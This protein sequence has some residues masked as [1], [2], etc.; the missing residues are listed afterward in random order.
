[1]QNMEI[2]SLKQAKTINKLRVLN[3]I[4]FEPGVT[5]NMI[6]EK[7][8][9][10]PS[11]VTKLVNEMKR[12]RMIY[13]KG[14]LPS[15][16]GRH[17]KRLYVNRD[18]SKAIVVDLGVTHSIVGISFFDGTVEVVD[19]FDTPDTPEECFRVLTEKV[20][21]FPGVFPLI[22]IGV[23]GSVDKT[24]KKL[25]FAPN[26]N[27]W[28]DIDV[29]KYFK[30]FE[31]YLENDANLAAL[32]EMM[33]NK[34]FG[35]RKNIVYIL[36]REGIG[37]GI[38]IEG[39][40]Y[41]GSFNAAGE[42][43]HMKMYD[44]GPCF[45]GRVGCWEANTSISHCVRQYE[46]KKPLPGRTMYEKFETLCKIYEEDPLAKEV[47]DEFTGILIDGI[48][49]LVNILSP[50]I[51]IVGGE[52][53]FLPEGVFEVI[54]SE[55]RRQVHPM[56]KEVSVEKGSLSNKEVVLEGTS[57]LSSMMISERLV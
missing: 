31:V 25:A 24:H 50:E 18:F 52:G 28:R 30:V 21:R 53:V 41:K 48:V 40:L 17:S 38:I 36:V 45:C 29:E 54:V 6:S 11:T 19:E 9:L 51:V 8:G 16:L 47:L 35:D 26:L 13:E 44:R 55:T 57:I 4:R 7:T 42:I 37:G 3:T 20:S 15:K 14:I 32:A 33:R 49:N 39:K 43:G 56:D 34:H 5:R 22:V 1:M 10:D 23:P 2:Y 46:K 12:K 27:R